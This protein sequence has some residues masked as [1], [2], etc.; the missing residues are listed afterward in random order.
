MACRLLTLGL[1]GP[2]SLLGPLGTLSPQLYRMPMWRDVR[3]GLPL[4]W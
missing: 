2:L 3:L 1:L 4:N